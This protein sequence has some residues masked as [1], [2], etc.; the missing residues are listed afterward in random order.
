M[1]LTHSSASLKGVAGAEAEAEGWPVEATA[2][3]LSR[4]GSCLDE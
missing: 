2:A 1:S 4:A 3:S